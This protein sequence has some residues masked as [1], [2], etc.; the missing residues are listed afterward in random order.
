[1]KP[2]PQITLSGF[3]AAVWCLAGTVQAAPDERFHGGFYDGAASATFVGYTPP[4]P[5]QFARY[6]GAGGY[7]GYSSADFVGYT[8]PAPGQFGRFRGDGFDGY[9]SGSG[10]HQ[11]NPLDGD[12]DGDGVP[13]WWESRHYLSLSLADAETDL[14]GDG[15][16]S[17]FE[18]VAD[19][20][21]NDASSR[22]AIVGF[23]R[24]E[25]I[26]VSSQTTSANRVYWIEAAEPLNPGD[27]DPVTLPPVPGNGGVLAISFPDAWDDV[28]F[29]RLRVAL[30]AE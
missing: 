6:L 23:E 21:P 18:Y 15:Q 19:L 30:P 22:L 28:G 16:G 14:D 11:I 12:S 7:D 2:H 1:M 9:A 8:P 13:D 5:G 17:L 25:D 20:D 4:A 3:L 24:G 10:L 27:W 29:F 26:V